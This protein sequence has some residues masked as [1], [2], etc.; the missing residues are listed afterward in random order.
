MQYYFCSC[1]LYGKWLK[2]N[3]TQRPINFLVRQGFKGKQG[4]LR[5]QNPPCVVAA[6]P[7]FFSASAGVSASRTVVC[8][9]QCAALTAMNLSP[10]SDRCI[11]LTVI[12]STSESSFKDTLKKLI[13][14]LNTS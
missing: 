10:H 8:V 1:I 13:G 5:F 7:S 14:M 4:P 2:I 6:L 9:S 12:Q 11:T 3:S